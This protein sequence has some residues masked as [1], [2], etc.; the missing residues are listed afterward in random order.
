MSLVNE[1]PINLA[2]RVLLLENLRKISPEEFKKTKLVKKIPRALVTYDE[3]TDNGEFIE[4]V[5]YNWE[6]LLF[7]TTMHQ[8]RVVFEEFFKQEAEQKQATKIIGLE[9]EPLVMTGQGVVAAEDV[10]KVK[11]ES[12]EIREIRKDMD[13][14]LAELPVVPEE[15]YSVEKSNPFPVKEMKERKEQLENEADQ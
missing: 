9:G 11:E 8:L 7:D 4:V 5:E 2:G 1:H 3:Q 15:C 10:Q 14:K 12:V 6:Y 13:A